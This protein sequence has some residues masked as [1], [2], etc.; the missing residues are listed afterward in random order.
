MLAAVAFSAVRRPR[1]VI[2]PPEVIIAQDDSIF[3]A[4]ELFEMDYQSA[5]LLYDGALPRLPEETFH[6]R[7]NARV[8]AHLGRWEEAAENFQVA[9][10]DSSI[11]SSVES[12]LERIRALA[13]GRTRQDPGI[14]KWERMTV[15]FAQNIGVSAVA[16]TGN[17]LIATAVPSAGSIIFWNTEG[18]RVA[19][20][21]G[22]GM[23][24]ALAADGEGVWIADMA[25]NRV[26]FASTSG[27]GTVIDLTPAGI[28]GVRS[29]AIG[30]DQSIWISDY[31][32]GR[33][34]RVA[35]D[36]TI[37]TQ[38]GTVQIDGLSSVLR[39]GRDLLVVE[40]QKNRV[41]RFNANGRLLRYYEHRS[42]KAPVSLA[43]AE[44]GFLV[45]ARNGLVFIGREKEE[46]LAGPLSSA[47]GQL[48][49]AELG[50]AE[51]VYGNLW[52]G[53]GASLK[54]ARRLPADAPAHLVEILRA[55]AE[56]ID[57]QEIGLI[58]LTA[59][60][61]RKDGIAIETLDRNS[62]RILRDRAQLV[63]IEVQN[64][65]QVLR[66][67]RIAAVMESSD[68]ILPHRE[69]LN[70]ALEY[71]FK[72][73]TPD[74]RTCI[75][76]VTD[77]FRVVRDFTVTP[78]LVRRAVLEDG[79]RVAALDL[80]SFDGIEYA[81]RL[82]APTDYARGIVWITS[83]EGMTDAEAKILTRMGIIN[84]V[85]LFILHVGGVNEGLLRNLASSTNGHY[86]QL[87]GRPSPI[88][89]GES[90]ARLRSGRYRIRARIPLPPP[91]I[92]G[93]WI[94][95]TLETQMLAEAAF[96]KA[97]YYSF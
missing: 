64:L 68:A 43:P 41:L 74:D 38:S 97:G 44:G 83:G 33:A 63:P 11:R 61:M 46:D 40:T 66:G 27:L 17:G 18:Q 85:P 76:A 93:Q 75:M 60:A 28:H 70:A 26:L 89:I 87:Y 96:D 25:G 94:P 56:R 23:A 9:A 92:R 36:G 14:G 3:A 2:P 52:W 20:V 8:L 80:K 50:V 59:S 88:G 78:D 29:V 4:Q 13:A 1:I 39:V 19:E 73:L 47:S 82:L 81:M 51:D 15:H 69:S 22:V 35:R 65:S 32:Q 37:I 86:F 49:T 55:R 71:F 10:M 34:V 72:A 30:E 5:H 53:D 77:T 6:R 45:Q 42:L 91:R 90:L 58:T 21:G 16:V 95:L 84:Q 31:G 67:R 24:A 62:F 54:M 12:D 48:Q 7:L 57:T 79:P